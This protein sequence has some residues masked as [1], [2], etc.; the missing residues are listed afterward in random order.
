MRSIVAVVPSRERPGRFEIFA[1]SANEHAYAPE[2][3]LIALVL[4]KDEP[5]EKEYRAVAG[6]Y[7]NV[8]VMTA[9]ER[10]S[11]P[12]LMNWGAL[13]TSEDIVMAASDD[14]VCRTHG[15]DRELSTALWQDGL[16]CVYFNNGDGRD[17][18]E[19][20][21]VG[22]EWVDAVGYFMRPEFKHFC[23]DQWV[24]DM[25]KSVGR[26]RWL[27]NVTFEHMHAKYG[28]A[29]WDETYKSK[30]RD[31]WSGAD[32]ALMVSLADQFER[33][34]DIVADLIRSA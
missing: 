18:V 12:G 23:A 20:F 11:V 31:N 33:D 28:K 26:A 4:D 25:A 29:V 5:R 2:R 15:W 21:A 6:R 19:H 30:R 7:A 32:N 1:K 9:P 14:I 24:G 3:V 27:R 16:G 13:N 8:L 10:L 17:R 34:R 22:R